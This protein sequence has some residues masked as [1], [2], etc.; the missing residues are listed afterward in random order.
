MSRWLAAALLAMALVVAAGV[1]FLVG[2]ARAPSADE[3]DGAKREAYGDA[4][5]E[6]RA[7]AE[8]EANV[9]ALTSATAKGRRAG[10][11]AGEADAATQL[12]KQQADSAETGAEQKAASP[13]LPA[14]AYD[15]FEEFCADQ[16]E[17]TECGGAGDPGP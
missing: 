1:G 8:R 16:P 14:G 15:S 4:F 12:A 2:D 9:E 5:N 13:D 7:S 17:E 3:L 11:E 6:A 10:A